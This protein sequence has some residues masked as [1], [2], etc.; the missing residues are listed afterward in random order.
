M[1]EVIIRLTRPNEVK[2]LQNLNN[3]VFIDNHQYDPDLKIDWALS[4][5]GHK[6][7]AELVNNR[8]AICLIAEVDDQ[9]VGYLA[10]SP[11]ISDYRISKCIELENMGVSPN[12]RSAGIGTKLISKLCDLAQDKGYLRLYVS[13]YFRNTEAINFYKRNGFNEIDVSLEKVL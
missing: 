7:F 12:F 11:K 9:P 5:D 3:E 1:S 8:D 6:Y 4:D 13:A 10:A 2:T